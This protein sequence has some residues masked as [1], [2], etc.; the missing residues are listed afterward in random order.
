MNDVFAL[1]DKVIGEIVAALQLA[2]P[3]TTGRG[4]PRTRGLRCPSAGTAA[5][6]PGQRGGDDRRTEAFDV[7][8]HSIRLCRAHALLAAEYDQIVSSPGIHSGAGYERAYEGMQKHLALAM[9]APT[10]LAHAW[11]RS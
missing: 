2:L 8:S 10:P 7:P 4:G 9:R 11:R 6:A 5:P 3:D 1:Q